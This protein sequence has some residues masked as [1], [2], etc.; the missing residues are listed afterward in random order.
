[1]QHGD[2]AKV[3][4]IGQGHRVR[5]GVR[6]GGR[7]AEPR[8]GGIPHEKR[9]HGETQLVREIVREHVAQDPGAAFD[10]ESSHLTCGMKIFEDPHQR[11][12]VPGVDDLGYLAEPRLGGGKG[13]RGAVH[14]RSAA[15]DGEE[16]G[17][18]VQ[19]PVFGQLEVKAS[20]LT[21]GVSQQ[22]AAGPGA[23]VARRAC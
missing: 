9:G 17:G 18:R 19:V 20:D 16:A 5:R 11:R 2:V 10:E 15:A 21:P 4:D 22:K 8:G 7:Q 3:A 1:V 14:Q 12:R 23:S 13:G 6:V